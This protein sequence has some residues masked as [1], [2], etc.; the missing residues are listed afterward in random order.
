M[1]ATSFVVKEA[2]LSRL[3]KKGALSRLEYRA[4][5]QAYDTVYSIDLNNDCE[6][7]L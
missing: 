2:A 5:S 7:I 4:F 1:E 3:V 6:Y